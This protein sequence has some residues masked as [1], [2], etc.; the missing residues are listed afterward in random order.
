MKLKTVSF[1]ACLLSEATIT[2]SDIIWIKIESIFLITI[3]HK[4]SRILATISFLLIDSPLKFSFFPHI[5]PVNFN[6]VSSSSYLVFS[7]NHVSNHSKPF[8]AVLF[9]N[10]IFSPPMNSL[11]NLSMHTLERYLEILFPFRFRFIEEFYYLEYLLVTPS[12]TPLMVLSISSL[13]CIMEAQ[14]F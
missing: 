2:C 1:I 9:L 13:L 10:L 11:E 3:F 12:I 6:P 8:R 4:F 5:L 14:V 7:L